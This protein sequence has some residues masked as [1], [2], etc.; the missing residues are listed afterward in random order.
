MKPYE[1]LGHTVGRKRTRTYL[2]WRNMISR[3][4]N[5][6]RPDYRHYGGRGITVCAEWMESFGKFLIDMGEC[7]HGL[8]LDRERNAEGYS[9]EN[10]R[11]ATK[12]QQMQN[13][14]ATRLLTLNSRSMGLTA[15]ARE[16][17]LNKSSIQ[18]RLNRGWSVEDTLTRK[19]KND[20]RRKS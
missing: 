3:C 4:T 16:L 5:K 20:Y 18:G 8:S 11:W 17:G 10:C 7:P 14:R 1:R 2:A 12:D 19:G 15:W 9:K 13:T 6:N